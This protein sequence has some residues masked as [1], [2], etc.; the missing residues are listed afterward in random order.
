MVAVRIPNPWDEVRFLADLPATA[1]TQRRLRPSGGATRFARLRE[2][3]GAIRLL[4]RR[5][6][7][8]VEHRSASPTARVRF[9]LPA[10]VLLCGALLRERHDLQNRGAR[11]D[12][13]ARLEI[14]SARG[15][16]QRLLNAGTRD[17]H[18]P[19]ARALRPISSHSSSG[20]GRWILNPATRVRFPH[21]TLGD[22]HI[23]THGG[24][25]VYE[26][27][28]GGS[29]PPGDASALRRRTIAALRK[30]RTGFDSRRRGSCADDPW[31]DARFISAAAEVRVLSSAL[32]RRP[33]GRTVAFD[34]IHL[35]SNPSAPTGSFGCRPTARTRA[36]D[37][38]DGGSNPSARTNVLS[39]PRR[40][41]S[42]W[43]TCFGN[44]RWRVRSPRLRPIARSTGGET[45]GDVGGLA[46]GSI[47]W[48]PTRCDHGAR[49]SG[50]DL[51]RLIS[52]PAEF[53]SR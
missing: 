36:S 32:E 13:A 23:S 38:R 9:P 31:R 3:T 24:Q 27:S 4:S 40:Q 5:Y 42:G 49:R 26:A 16:D 28:S 1:S 47:P 51:A 2:T 10:L 15:R 8:K 6:G 18:A 21:A 25:Q 50:F 48:P 19:E 29:T 33:T 14:A 17:R 43:A 30:L 12:S 7:S 35:G 34:A 41:G 46:Q 44:T 53:D 45:A 52:V 22:S 20:P 11:F 39:R 37:A